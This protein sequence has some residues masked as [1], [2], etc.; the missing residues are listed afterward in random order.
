M[1]LE[2]YAAS[3]VSFEAFVGVGELVLVLGSCNHCNFKYFVSSH[4]TCAGA[5]SLIATSNTFFS[6]HI[7]ILIVFSVAI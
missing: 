1:C 5:G 3:S 4:M 7:I 6:R 2:T